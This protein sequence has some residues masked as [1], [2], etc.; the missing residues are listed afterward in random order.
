LDFEGINGKGKNSNNAIRADA[1]SNFEEGFIQRFTMMG[2]IAHALVVVK[3]DIAIT[4]G[5]FD[6]D[7]GDVFTKE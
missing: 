6:T 4:D 7:S 3:G 2:H 5:P 1:S